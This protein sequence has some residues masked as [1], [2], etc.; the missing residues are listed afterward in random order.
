MFERL[1]FVVIGIVIAVLGFQL[2]TLYTTQN[3]IYSAP[4]EYAI[5]PD[6]ADLTVVEFIDYSCPYCQG[7]QPVI[8]EAMARDG[9]VRLI[10]RPIRSS[11]T[12]A[13]AGAILVYAAAEQGKFQEVHE[14]LIT[15]LPPLGTADDARAFAAKMGLDGDQLLASM[16]KKEV[17][18]RVDQN[19]EAILNMQLEGVPAFLIGKTKTY[20][21][22]ENTTADDFLRMFDEARAE[23]TN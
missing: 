4:K 20:V 21:G 19:H 1:F 11:N 7:I 16:S 23:Q 9:K 18:A 22:S 3:D 15:N 6:D 12:D 5:G 8:K 13:L 10:P 2:Y 17:Q 14:E